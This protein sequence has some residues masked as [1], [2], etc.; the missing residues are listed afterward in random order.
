[1][2]RAWWCRPW[3]HL[4]RRCLAGFSTVEFPFPTSPYCTLWEEVT[5]CSPQLSRGRS[6]FFHWGRSIYRHDLEFLCIRDS[7]LLPHLWIY[8]II[9]L[10]GY[11][12]YALGYN[13]ILLYLFWCSNRSSVGRWELFHLPPVLFWPTHIDVFFGLFFVGFCFV[14]VFLYFLA[15]QCAPGSS[16]IF[17]VPVLELDISL[18]S[19]VLFIGK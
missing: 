7:S 1:M 18:R 12:F 5:L 4:L 6:C 16:W 19:F 15:L 17:S 11:L 2:I 13:P 9:Y 14:L 8:S 3:S 10:H